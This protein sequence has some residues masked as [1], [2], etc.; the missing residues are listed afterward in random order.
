MGG[1]T[2]CQLGEGSTVISDY[3][4]PRKIEIPDKAIREATTAF[5]SLILTDNNEVVYWGLDITDD[6]S[7]SPSAKIIPS[8]TSSKIEKI[9]AGYHMVLLLT[10]DGELFSL[11][12]GYVGNG[13]NSSS[14]FSQSISL[15]CAIEEELASQPTLIEAFRG[16]R[17]VQA[18]AAAKHFGAVTDD[19]G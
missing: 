1:N 15:T 5:S 11:G 12:R 19:G 13:S 14:P 9:V 8:F 17:V 10:Q 3:K 18:S 7:T 4:K 2:F 6:V 16:K